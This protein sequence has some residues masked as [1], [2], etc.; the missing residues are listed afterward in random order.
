MRFNFPYYFIILLQS[1]HRLAK[2]YHPDKNPGQEADEKVIQFEDN[3]L[4]YFYNYSLSPYNL[5]T[6]YYLILRKES[7]T[8]DLVWMHLKMVTLEWAAWEWMGFQEV[9]HNDII[10]NVI[11]IKIVFFGGGGFGGGDIFSSIFEG[12]LFGGRGRIATC[13]VMLYYVNLIGG[14]RR[15]R[16]KPEPLMFPLE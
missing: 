1:Y 2:Q 9:S 12:G 5:H 6:K 3:I 14:Y 15:Q 10:I 8:I 7:C 16:S 13:H 4:F 11:I